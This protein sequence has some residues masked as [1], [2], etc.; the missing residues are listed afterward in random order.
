MGKQINFF[1]L[2]EDVAEIDAKVKELGLSIIADRM[3]TE[4]LIVLDSLVSEF[5]CVY[6]L[7][8]ENLKN[9]KS[10]YSEIRN[11]YWIHPMH[12]PAL[13]Y[14]KSLNLTEDKLITLGRIFYD[15]EFYNQQHDYVPK[16]EILT[17]AVEKLFRWFKNKFKQK[18]GGYPVGNYTYNFAKETNFSLKTSTQTYTIN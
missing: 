15:K 12:I 4:E 6:L 2:P 3:P 8:E 1:M 10:K 7:F 11:H 5:Q 16:S 18:I 13:E 17:N 9:I 14:S